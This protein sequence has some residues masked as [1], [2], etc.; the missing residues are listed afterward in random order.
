MLPLLEL[1]F[2]REGVAVS[3]SIG[4]ILLDRSSPIA[5]ALNEVL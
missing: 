3:G 1:V 4:D 2:N 5:K